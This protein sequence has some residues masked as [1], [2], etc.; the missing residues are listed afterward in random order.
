MTQEITTQGISPQEAQTKAPGQ[1]TLTPKA[2][3]L[4]ASGP[5]CWRGSEVVYPLVLSPWAQA[6]SAHST[7][8]KQRL[9]SQL[10]VSLL[11]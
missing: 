7:C 6:L 3:A 2:Y 5:T 11:V 1:E 8:Y 9:P 4:W 10:G